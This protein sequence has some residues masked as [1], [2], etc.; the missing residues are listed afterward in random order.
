MEATDVIALAEKFGD[1]PCCSGLV[2]DCI[3]E[4][5]RELG[6]CYCFLKYE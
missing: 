4:I 6:A 1:C 3:G 2:F 5:C